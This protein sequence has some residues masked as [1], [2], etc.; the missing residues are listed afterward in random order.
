[1]F[2]DI[3]KKLKTAQLAYNKA[4][5]SMKSRVIPSMERF[6]EMGAGSTEIEEPDLL[7]IGSEEIN[8]DEKITIEEWYLICIMN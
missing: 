5:N 1:M 3:G 4:S 2:K 6:K 8:E 7:D